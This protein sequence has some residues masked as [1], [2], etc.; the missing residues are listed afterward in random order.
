[1]YYFILLGYYCP[2]NTGYNLQPCPTGKFSNQFKLKKKSECTPCS[3]GK[4]CPDLNAT[5]PAGY[6]EGGFYCRSESD[7]ATPS[8]SNKGDA[9]IC[10]PGYYCPKGNVNSPVPCP[11]GTFN[12][13]THANSSSYCKTCT[14]GFYCETT[15]LGF[16]TGKCG[17]GFYCLQ[18][19]NLKS[20]TNTTADYGPCPM[21]H[22]C[23]E[24]TA[25]P[26]KCPAGTYNGNTGQV[27]CTMCPEN[28]YCPRGSSNFTQCPI[29]YYCPN[30]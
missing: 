28:Y 18:G 19:S 26:F 21:G 22:H 23:P 20:P 4:F 3:V 11:A 9:G 6:C 10:Q 30:G 14:G 8:G 29:G 13:E 2:N 25:V 15:G 16:P 17:P 27:N 1:M 7:T 5:Q 12:N 24:G